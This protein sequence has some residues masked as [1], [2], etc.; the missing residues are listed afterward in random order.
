MKA[1]IHKIAE[2]LHIY[3]S[4]WTQHIKKIYIANNM[5][6]VMRIN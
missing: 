5:G 3:S 1:K 2:N 6:K 4:T